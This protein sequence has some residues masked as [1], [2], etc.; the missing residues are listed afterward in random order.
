L[1]QGI[2][3]PLIDLP[4]NWMRWATA[5]REP[6]SPWTRDRVTLPGV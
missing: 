5:N 6:I 1:R 2:A 4:R 3:R